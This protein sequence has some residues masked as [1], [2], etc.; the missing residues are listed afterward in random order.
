MF[1]CVKL[2]KSCLVKP[3]VLRVWHR[4]P[5]KADWGTDGDLKMVHIAGTLNPSDDLTKPLGWVLH[6]RHCRRMMGHYWCR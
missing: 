1:A 2:G 3:I 6:T 5:N 4:R